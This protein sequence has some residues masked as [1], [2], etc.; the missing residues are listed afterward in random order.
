M[1]VNLRMPYQRTAERRWQ[2]VL[3]S[4]A[5]LL[6]T[7]CGAADH[8]RVRGTVI[9]KDGTPLAGARVVARSVETGKSAYGTTDSDGRFELRGGAEEDGI[10]GGDYHVIVLEDRGDPDQRKRPTIGAKYRD[11][12]TSG[13]IV[14]VEPGDSKEFNLTLDPP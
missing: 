12:A 8:G 9:R 10:P 2:L 6:V 14:S 5:L 11:S 4:A 3:W 13:L 7:G 1:S